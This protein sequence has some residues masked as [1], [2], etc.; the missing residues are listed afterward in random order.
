M[1]S[2]LGRLIAGRAFAS[3]V[4]LYDDLERVA[5]LKMALMVCSLAHLKPR[6]K[7]VAFGSGNSPG[8]SYSNPR[9]VISKY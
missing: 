3:L 9:N 6:D 2:A 7:R 4:D 8:S 1:G 5:E